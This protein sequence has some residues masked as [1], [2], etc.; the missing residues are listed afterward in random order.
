MMGPYVLQDTVCKEKAMK[1]WIVKYR[2]SEYLRKDLQSKRAVVG[3]GVVFQLHSNMWEC[4]EDIAK[5]T[6]LSENKCYFR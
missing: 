4:Q 2:R 6:W 5:R 3:R 1:K